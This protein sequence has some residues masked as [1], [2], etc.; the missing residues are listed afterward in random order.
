M[1]WVCAGG[2]PSNRRAEAI[3]S[4][5]PGTA[6][7]P[8]VVEDSDRTRLDAPALR[9]RRTIRWRHGARQQ[10]E[11]AELR[12]GVG[13]HVIRARNCQTAQPSA[14]STS[15]TASCESPKVNPL[16]VGTVKGAR[17]PFVCSSRDSFVELAC[18][19]EHGD[20]RLRVRVVSGML[21]AIVAASNT[22][23]PVSEMSGC[24]G[25]APRRQEVRRPPVTR[26]RLRLRAGCRTR[27]PWSVRSPRAVRSESRGT[28][29]VAGS[30]SGL[31]RYPRC[32]RTWARHSAGRNPA[33]RARR[34]APQTA[35]PFP[36]PWLEKG[37]ARGS[38]GMDP[39]ARA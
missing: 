8:E 7:G 6:E 15:F 27:D 19:D 13:G 31:L 30:V 33:G 21:E 11:R 18:L 9:R 35:L 28:R 37:S 39:S 24:P 12:P 38:A 16:T 20:R 36:R 29:S 10:D 5:K 17:H 4:G 14:A 26:L 34:C 23:G 2:A 1:R 3:R 25:L 32:D 22:L